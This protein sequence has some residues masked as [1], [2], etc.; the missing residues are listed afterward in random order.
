MFSDT[1]IANADSL[2]HEEKS[3]SPRCYKPPHL[4]IVE[5]SCFGIIQEAE[6]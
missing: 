3:V 4:L 6:H 2:N 1:D 5:Y